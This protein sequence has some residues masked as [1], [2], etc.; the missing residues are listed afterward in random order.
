MVWADPVDSRRPSAR[1]DLEAMT[2]DADE[3]RPS[4]ALDTAVTAAAPH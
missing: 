2:A 1:S 3:Q 4:A